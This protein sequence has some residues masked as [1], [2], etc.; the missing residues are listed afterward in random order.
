[1]TEVEQFLLMLEAI[2][3]DVAEE[4][5][6]TQLQ[7][8][9]TP[10]GEQFAK[11]L[12][13]VVIPEELDESKRRKVGIGRQDDFI[14]RLMDAFHDVATKRNH[15]GNRVCRQVVCTLMPT[16]VKLRFIVMPEE[17]DVKMNPH[18]DPR[19]GD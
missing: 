18:I 16:A 9:Y 13:I 10:P 4:G 19:E 3:I 6:I 2:M 7:S 12:R 17:M 5:N 1:M 14:N 8:T 11:V 15:L